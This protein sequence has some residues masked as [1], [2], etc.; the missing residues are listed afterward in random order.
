VS[1]L[2]AC[3]Q[4]TVWGPD[5]ADDEHGW[6]EPTEPVQVWAGLGNVQESAVSRTDQGASEPGGGGPY[7]PVSLNSAVAYLPTDCGVAPGMLVDA[8]AQQWL[9]E[10]VRLVTDPTGGGL[11][12]VQADLVERGGETWQPSSAG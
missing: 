1:V 12:C 9:V 6:A 3:D 10:A 4:V 11:G 2:L 8:H 5:T 7:D